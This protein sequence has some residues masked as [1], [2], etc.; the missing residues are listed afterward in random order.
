MNSTYVFNEYFVL[1]ANSLYN[2]VVKFRDYNERHEYAAYC[3]NFIHFFQPL[4]RV[5]IISLLV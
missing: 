3:Y 4:F 2:I 1:S 5:K